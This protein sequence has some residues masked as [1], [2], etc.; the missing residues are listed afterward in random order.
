MLYGG[1]DCTYMMTHPLDQLL[2]RLGSDVLTSSHDDVVM[3]TGSRI[4]LPLEP[5]RFREILPAETPKKMAFVDGGNGMVAESPAFIIS[6]NRLYYTIFRGRKRIGPDRIS[7]VE[8]F[9]L[10]T[11]PVSSEGHVRYHTT[12]FTHKDQHRSFMPDPSDVDSDVRNDALSMDMRI[13]TRARNLGEWRMAERVAYTLEDGDVLVIDGSLVT[14]DVTESRYAQAAFDAAKKQG[15]TICGLSKTSQ[16]RTQSGEPLLVRAM[17]IAESVGHD[18]WSV[19]V[20]KEIS[21]NDRGYVMAVKLHPKSPLAYRF[22][23]LREQFD[24]ADLDSILGSLAANSQDGSYP[25]YPY[26]L[27]DAD[28]FARVR[29]SDIH[30][31]RGRL[32]SMMR[33]NPDL[34]RIET[35]IQH[36][37]AH[38]Y[39]NRV[40]G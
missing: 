11:R 36:A 15:V 17:E 13:R 23:I 38:D 27:I 5:S 35:A 31:C 4:G 2:N 40:A 39:L 12:L 25:G 19:R 9:S 21:A 28:R 29:N 6:L 14:H 8:F 16:L 24:D 7:R 37:S 26:G 33:I 3:T 22:E 10:T 32:A 34:T 20:A 18:M 30:I 1:Q